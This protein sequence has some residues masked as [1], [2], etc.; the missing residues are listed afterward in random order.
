MYALEGLEG[1]EHVGLPLS[2]YFDVF[3]CELCQHG[4]VV[5]VQQF[6]QLGV[7]PDHLEYVIAQ[8][9]VPLEDAVELNADDVVGAG[10]QQSLDVVVLHYFGEL[11]L[12]HALLFLR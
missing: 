11:V 12:P 2:T 5:V 10:G 8:L 6:Q 4:V 7:G 3:L 1:H 9:Y